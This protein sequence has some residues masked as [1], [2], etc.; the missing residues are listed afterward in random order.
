MKYRI[1]TLIIAFIVCLQA[2]SNVMCGMPQIYNDYDL[3]S[4]DIKKVDNCQLPFRVDFNYRVSVA[5]IDTSKQL[6]T[7][8]IPDSITIEGLTFKVNS[9]FFNAFRN[10]K[11]LKSITLNNNIEYICDNAFMGCVALSEINIPASIKRVAYNAF[12]SCISLSKFIVDPQNINYSSLDG[13]L[14]DKDKTILIRVPG[15]VLGS[16]AIPST[17][18]SIGVNAFKDC[19][20]ITNVNLPSSVKKIED[21]SFRGCTSLTGITIPEN[22]GKINRYSFYGCTNLTNITFS[23]NVRDIDIYAFSKTG[24]KNIT[25]PLSLK[26]IFEGAFSECKNLETVYINTNVRDIKATAFFDCPNLKKINVDPNNKNYCSQ[27]GVLYNKDK[28]KLIWVPDGY[29]GH[30]TIPST[31]T[32]IAEKAFSKCNKLTSIEI[33]KS[34]T[35][36]E[37]DAFIDCYGLTSIKIPKSVIEFG[38]RAFF[39][40]KNADIKIDNPVHKVRQGKFVFSKCKSVKWK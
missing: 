10:H 12:D 39:N 11:T 16:I 25:T 20:N 14:Y 23:E 24:L 1:L 37:K 29:S 9:I 4:G 31:V 18:S 6:E 21:N 17:V 19:K 30:F 40:C 3:K 15:G 35:K 13:V 34:V 28:T 7:V 8:I 26:W 36:I 32:C 5:E 33:P 2:W 27:D 38:T 22:V